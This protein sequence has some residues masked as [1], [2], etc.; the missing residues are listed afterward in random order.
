MINKIKISII[1]PAELLQDYLY[2]CDSI[3]DSTKSCIDLKVFFRF[4][5][6]PSIEELR[7]ENEILEGIFWVLKDLE[8]TGVYSAL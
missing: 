6:K 7:R 5:T 2:L 3:S 1:L 8:K 4:D